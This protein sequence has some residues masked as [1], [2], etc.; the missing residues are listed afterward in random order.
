MNAQD[1]NVQI[2]QAVAQALG[3]LRKDLVFVGG[4]AAGLLITDKSRP[5]VR[6]TQD[7][8]LI[9]EVTAQ[10]EYYKL[11]EQLKSLGFR[12][13]AEGPLC[14]WR[15]NGLQVD[16]MPISEEV[17]GFTNRW[18]A[19]SI[20]TAQT[21]VL[22]NG[23]E[24]RLIDASHFLATKVEAFHG[25]GGGD[26][27]SHDLEDI[28]NVIDGRPSIAEEVRNQSEPLQ[29][30]LRDE[31]EELLSTPAFLDALPGHLRP[32]D[33]GRVPLVLQRMRAISGL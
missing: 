11:C 4:C 1:P 2:L 25:R 3:N 14:R 32:T 21:I 23:N 17:L 7:V 27:G 15:L 9:A 12:E 22:P 5:S 29:E 33:Q 28:I 13:D 20:R 16:V 18:Y 30:Y 6:A 26:F 31:L 24:I 8:D 19:E 10:V